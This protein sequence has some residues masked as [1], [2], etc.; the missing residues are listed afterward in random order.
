MND[1]ASRRGYSRFF[2]HVTGNSPYP[3]QEDLARAPHSFP[4]H[5]GRRGP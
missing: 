1:E 5:G 3:Y 2:A 4:A